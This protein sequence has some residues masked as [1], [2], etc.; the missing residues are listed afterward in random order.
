MI[1]LPPKPRLISQEGSKAIFEIE[2][3]YPGYGQTIGNSLRRVLLSSLK[4][5]AVTSVKIEGVEHEFS[6]IEGVMEDVVE[7]ILNIKQLRF[8]LFEGGPFTI[9]LSAKG[10]KDVTGGDFKVP[11]QLELI[12]TNHHI[13]TLASKKS[14]LH[15]EAVVESGLGY[16][17]VETRSKDKVEVGTIALDA[18]F[19]PVRYVNYEVEHMRVG[20]R[21]DYNKVRFTIETDGS[22]TPFEALSQAAQ[23]LEIQFQSIA[24]GLSEEEGVAARARKDEE[25]EGEEKEDGTDISKMKIED[26]GISNRAQNALRE[27]GIKTV[28]GLSRKKESVLREIE[29]LGEK[30]LQEILSALGNLGI[31]LKE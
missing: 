2:G 17:P 28:G 16:I 19:S 7:I 11:S 1:S 4:G 3:L 30:G 5:A 9:M 12:N 6:T 25:A 20:D 24:K 8:R 15:M 21:T 22:I 13:A 23:I 10:E 27:A 31:S 26:L 29:G 14:S 18:A